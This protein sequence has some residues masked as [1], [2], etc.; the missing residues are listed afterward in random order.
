MFARSWRVLVVS[1]FSS[2]AYER[3]ATPC[4]ELWRA[5]ICAGIGVWLTP[6]EAE[7]LLKI[8]D[9]DG[10]G[11]VDQ[12]EFESFWVN[13]PPFRYGDEEQK[14]YWVPRR[15]TEDMYIEMLHYYDIRMCYPGADHS[16]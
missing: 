9:I 2:C 7:M 8:V 16:K 13:S 14:S 6:V 1:D 5:R 15:C 4:D 10:S 12:E 11:E 3:F